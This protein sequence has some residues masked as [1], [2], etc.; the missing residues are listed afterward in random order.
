M[1][2]KKALILLMKHTNLPVIGYWKKKDMYIFN[3][4]APRDDF[5]A[6]AIFIVE[7]SGNVYPSTNPMMYGI[8]LKNMIKL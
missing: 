7:N 2:L 4:K 5:T 3:V 6:P 8:S 1:D